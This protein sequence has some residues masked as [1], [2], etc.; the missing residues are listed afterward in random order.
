MCKVNLTLCCVRFWQI[1]KGFQYLPME[2]SALKE[3][4]YRFAI[5][6]VWFCRK[7]QENNREY[8]ITRQL[9]R[10]GT[11]IGAMIREAEF[12]ESRAD[13]SHKHSIALKEANES[14]Y[15]LDILNES[16]FD[17]KDDQISGLR[18]RC[19]ELLAMLV[20]S[21]KKTKRVK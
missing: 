12:A 1:S 5:D 17:N 13:F 18:R 3:K 10:S 19:V 2:K 21:V 7:V 16:Y 4:S 15:W 11:S 6:I 8:I 14:I 9:L 20:S